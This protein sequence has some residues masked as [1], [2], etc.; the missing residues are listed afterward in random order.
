MKYDAIVLGLGAMGS[1]SVHQLAKRG[2]HVLGIDRFSPPHE[3]GSSHGGTRVTRLAIGEGEHYTPLVIRSHEIWREVERETGA[4]LLSQ[5][6][7]LIVS[8]ANKSAVTH[9][10]GFFANTVAAARKYAIAHEL[11]DAPEIRRRYPQFAVGDEEFG[12]FEPS[13]GFLRPEACVR[14]QL[15]LARK[16]GAELHT[17]EAV[18]GFDALPDGVTVTTDKGTYSAGRLIVAA[19]AWLPGLLGGRYERLFKVFRQ[20]Q[21]WFEVRGEPSQFLPGRFPIFIWELPTGR[22]GI[23]GFPAIDGVA[24]GL[25]IAT[26]YFENA[27][28]PRSVV[29]DVSAREIA[30][31]YESLVAPWLPG[32]GPRCVKA[33]TCLYTVTPDF[34]F[35]ID[36][37]PESE[38][39]ILASP[40]SGHGFKHAPALGE[41]LAELVLEGRSRHDL[42]AFRLDRFGG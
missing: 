23:Y 41:A 16:R 25:K 26:E 27:T 31:M 37:H 20:V 10:E 30:S 36:R 34:G 19:G 17:D 33:V 28:E 4:N 38:R 32:I 14:A 21:C 13:A 40:C 29:R 18:L 5:C 35:V 11:L 2:A 7:G 15:E 42:A 24:G 39:V 8:S 9:V 12:Y 1:A 3:F 6:G 22:Q